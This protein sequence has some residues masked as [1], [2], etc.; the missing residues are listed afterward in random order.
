[1]G[2]AF[3]SI[4]GVGAISTWANPG[5][6]EY[7]NKLYAI[8]NYR[9]SAV[10]KTRTTSKYVRVDTVNGSSTGGGGAGSSADPYKVRHMA[11]LRTLYTAQ[12]AANTAWYLRNGD[13][14]EANAA[15]SNQGIV[16]AQAN[17]S[18]QGYVDSASPSDIPPAVTGFRTVTGGVSAGGNVYEYTSALRPYWVRG[19]LAGS[20]YRAYRDQPYKRMT[21]ALAVAS[22]PYS[23]Y[24]DG[25]SLTTVNIGAH[26]LASV[27]FAYATGAGILL[28]NND[29]VGV[30]GVIAEGWGCE[31]MGAAGG[32]N[33][34]RSEAASNTEH[35][36][37]DCELYWGPYHTSGHFLTGTGGIVSWIRCRWGLYGWQN[38]N[39]DGDANVAFASNG[40]HEC[41][42]RACAA[43]HAGLPAAAVPTNRGMPT[44]GH[45]NTG[46]APRIVVML[47]QYDIPV[48]GTFGGCSY[49]GECPDLAD[50][51]AR[52]TLSNY[53]L[54]VHNHQFTGTQGGT[55][56]DGV[57]SPD[58]MRGII[59][60]CQWTLNCPRPGGAFG[61]PHSAG[62]TAR[63]K[64]IMINCTETLNLTGSWS[65]KRLRYFNGTANHNHDIIN[66]HIRITGSQPDGIDWNFGTYLQTSAH[67]N[68]IVSNETG[69]SDLNITGASDHYLESDP[70]V[71]AGGLS[72]GA[73]YGVPLAQY[74]GTPGYKTLTQGQAVQAVTFPPDSIMNATLAIPSG[75]ACVFDKDMAVRNTTVT[76]RTIGPIEGRPVT[77]AMRPTG[78]LGYATRAKR[79]TRIPPR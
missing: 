29:N 26:D 40:D 10:G 58:S 73:F 71:A 16:N 36:I 60:N 75:T 27:Q 8:A 23:Y 20:T 5:T 30:F 14:F 9:E 49:H 19:K 3:S 48:Y 57:L 43:T 65:G 33:C 42:R 61:Q 72:A 78:S 47:D 28:Q 21:S 37:I 74:N 70:S 67:W 12:N 11:D 38:T 39:G 6:Q 31:N 76:R 66:C 62:S 77:T 53:R 24:D 79:I 22:E 52:R 18:I 50:T 68:T 44:Y 25:A 55:S 41:V 2:T 34:I 35:L 64:G 15:N 45:A 17:V 32:G 56:A 4:P 69:A 59:T 51:T 13:Q 1:M 7:L 46:V 63:F 54:F